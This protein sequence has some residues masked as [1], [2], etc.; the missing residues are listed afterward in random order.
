MTSVSRVR[1]SN[2]EA[3]RKR[4]SPQAG[5][6]GTSSSTASDTEYPQPTHTRD[7]AV[8]SLDSRTSNPSS[9]SKVHPLQPRGNSNDGPRVPWSIG[10]ETVANWKIAN[11]NRGNRIARGGPP[12]RTNVLWR[13]RLMGPI[14]VTRAIDAPRDLLFDFLCD[15]ANRPAFTDHF[16]VE[17]RLER[18]ES[19]G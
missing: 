6:R 8:S 19:A 7:P 4:V 18:F 9:T 5:H 10:T 14:S 11:G 13:S 16:L 17:Y 2:R 3:R 15:L 12:G 1:D